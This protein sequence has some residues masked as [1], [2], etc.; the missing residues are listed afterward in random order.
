MDTLG[1]AAPVR[2]RRPPQG[3][4]VVD[5]A[6]ALLAAFDAEHRSLT[7]GELSRRSEIPTSSTLRLAS[8]LVA[9]GALERGRDGR[10]SVGLRLWEVASLAPR[11]HGLRQVALPFMGDLA[12]VTRQ[13]VQLAVR[14]GSEA[15]LV[16]RLSGHQAIPVLYRVGGRLPLHS[17]GVGLVLL[18]FAEVEFQEHI[19]AEPLMHQPENVAVSPAALRRT[20]A[21]IRRERAATVRRRSPEPRVSVA[22]PIFGA[23]D[24]VT[25]ALSVVV[26]LHNVAPRLL[27]PAVR[28]AARSIS[29]S[30]GASRSIGLGRAGIDASAG[31]ETP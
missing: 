27:V 26:P 10:F 22:A 30:L 28:T 2:G 11:G 12:E 21:E 9:W 7:L 13:H 18:A 24:R 15:L 29:R 19:L 6:F 3:E 4:P 8:R 1:P 31:Q 16:E 23:D 14:D 20:L 17:T 25:A 5:R